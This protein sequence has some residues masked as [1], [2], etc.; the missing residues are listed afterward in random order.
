M[1]GSVLCFVAL[2]HSCFIVSESAT[3]KENVAKS[4][5]ASTPRH[6]NSQ[7]ERIPRRWLKVCFNSDQIKHK[8]KLELNLQDEE[9]TQSLLRNEFGR[10]PTRESS[11]GDSES[12][13]LES[14]LDWI[15]NSFFPRK[16]A[17]A[18]IDGR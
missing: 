8:R 3:G 13:K 14:T 17:A 15:L 4:F 18:V 2:E 7:T 10:L 12:S 1:V 5:L 9:D 11:F 16:C 6:L